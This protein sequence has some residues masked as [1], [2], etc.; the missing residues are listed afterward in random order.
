MSVEYV[1]LVTVYLQVPLG[2]RAEL[3]QSFSPGKQLTE[4]PFTK[5]PYSTDT[6]NLLHIHFI[7]SGKSTTG[8]SELPAYPAAAGGPV[9]SMLELMTR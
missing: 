6:R 9:R 1:G 8:N 2:E 7:L 5:P 3:Q 4:K